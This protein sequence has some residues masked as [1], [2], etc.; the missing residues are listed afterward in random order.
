M[1]NVT[2][3]ER[4]TAV[5]RNS[6]DRMPKVTPEGDKR[7]RN[8]QK[9]AAIFA[10]PR[11]RVELQ[12]LKLACIGP[13]LQGASICASQTVGKPLTLSSVE[14]VQLSTASAEHFDRE[15]SFHELPQLAPRRH[16]RHHGARDRT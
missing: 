9:C 16:A 3:Y 2:V 7:D 8:P 1:Y 4:L 15:P 13:Q 14:P 11:P 6:F 10:E 5:T 12:S